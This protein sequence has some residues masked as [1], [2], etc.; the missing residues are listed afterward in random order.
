MEIPIFDG[1]NDALTA[2]HHG[3]L[4]SGS[5]QGHVDFP[6]MR[7]GGMRGGIFA[8]FSESARNPVRLRRGEDGVLR[9]PFAS[10]L[11]HARAVDAAATAAG[12]LFALERAG[13]VTIARGIAD[14]DDAFA[15]PEMGTPVAVLHLE[16]AEAIDPEL[17]ALELWY[18]AGLRSLGPVWSRPNAFGSGVPF[19]FGAGPDTGPG[20]TPAGRRLVSRCAELGVLVDLAH[21]NEAGFWDVAALEPGPLVC[22]HAGACELALTSRNL[23]DAQLDAIRDSGGLVGIVF[24]VYFLDPRF[25]VDPELGI[26]LIVDHIRYVADRIGVEHVALGSDFDGTTVPAALGSAAGL[27]LLIAALAQAGFDRG[28]REAIAWRNWRRVLDAWWRD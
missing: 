27:G 11:P 2:E 28:E 4:A 16:G 8:V 21:L 26:S 20:L 23:T 1:H 25:R 6:R 19:W 5:D 18:A 24:A 17:A 10:P 3:Q 15:A 22:S 13:E 14:F 9:R 12:R 7:A